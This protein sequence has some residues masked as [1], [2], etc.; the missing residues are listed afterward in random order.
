MCD[1]FWDDQDAS[2]VCRMLGYSPYGRNL[3][4]CLITH[5]LYIFHDIGASALTDSFTEGNWYIH[6]KDLNCTGNESSIWDCPMNELTDYSCYHYDDASVICQC[7]Y[8]SL[9]HH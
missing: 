2:V 1:H 6:I 7:M 3:S 5:N 8:N 9:A 4:K